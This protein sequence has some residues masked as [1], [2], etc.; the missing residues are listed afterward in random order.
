M[1]KIK[2]VFVPETVTVSTVTKTLKQ[3]ATKLPH[4]WQQFVD[5]LDEDQF[6]RVLIQASNANGQQNHLNCLRFPIC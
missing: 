5:K 1:W 3:G 6:I 2:L 4:R